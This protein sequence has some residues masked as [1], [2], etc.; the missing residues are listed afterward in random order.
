MQLTTL[1]HASQLETIAT[2]PNYQ[3]ILKHNTT[4]PISKGV[5]ERMKASGTE[6]PG[7]DGIYVLDL[8]A[9][10]DISNAI[11]DRFGV[12]HQSPQ[13]LL[14]K[15]GKCVYDEWGYD[16]SAEATADAMV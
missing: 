16:I 12:E 13:L 11:A 3:V 14:I 5:L 7:V 10:R 15:E 4:C 8:L 1:D 9:H 2:A 6:L